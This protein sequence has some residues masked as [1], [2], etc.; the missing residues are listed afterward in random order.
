MRQ[1]YPVI[2]DL[3]GLPCV[4]IG[5]GPLAEE[6][7]ATL[8]AAGAQVTVVA[9]SLTPNL[10]SSAEQ[11]KLRWLARPVEAGDLRGAFLA[12]AADEDRSRNTELA[13]EA[14]RER[15]LFNALD[16]PPNCRF[17]F[18]SVYRQGA[19][20]VAIST[21]GLAPALAVRIRERLSAEFGKE[22]AAFLDLATQWRERIAATVPDPERRKALW[23]RLVDSEILQLLRDSKPDAAQRLFE[24][25]VKAEAVS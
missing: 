11:N 8:L 18:P 7:T 6:K 16:D 22:Y 10:R 17:I 1:G 2:L 19:L 12:I 4:V 3:E 25:L 21:T 24:D 5:G 13:A 23:Y 14:E 15:V 20:T 9:P